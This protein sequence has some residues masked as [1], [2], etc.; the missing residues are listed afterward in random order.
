MIEHLYEDLSVHLYE[1][2]PITKKAP[3]PPPIIFL[4]QWRMMGNSTVHTDEYLTQWKVEGNSVVSN[5]SANLP[6]GYKKCKYLEFHGTEYIFSGVNTNDTIGANIS[7]STNT[8]NKELLGRRQSTTKDGFIVGMYSSN[9]IY[10]AYGGATIN[11]DINM[12]V[13][14]GNKHTIILDSEKFSVDGTLTTI[15]RGT[16]NNYY[17]IQ[18]GGWDTSAVSLARLFVGKI[19]NVKLY[20]SN[21]NLFNGIP[22]LDDNNVPCLY[23]TVTN[24]AFYNDGTG[25]FGYE[26]EHPLIYS[27][28][29]Y[30]DV[31]GKY[32]VKISNGVTIY[33]IP[34]TE[35][36]RKVNDVADTIEFAN[37]V[38]T[39]TRNLKSIDIGNMT[40]S[41]LQIGSSSDYRM[42]SSVIDA[43]SVEATNKTP[44]ML[45][46]AY[47]T[48]TVDKIYSKQTGISINTAHIMQ[49]YDPDYNQSNSASAFKTAMNGVELI[50]ELA[51]PTT[52]VIQ[53]SPFPISP[54]DTYT[55]ANDTPYSAFEYKKN[56]EIWSCGEYNPIDGKYH[57]LVQP[58]GGSIADIALDEP[59]RK[60]NDVADSIE[61][62]DGVATVTRYFQ[63]M[64]ITAS[65]I[66]IIN[67]TINCYGI[68]NFTGVKND[69]LCMC[70]GYT[71]SNVAVSE[72]PDMSV[73]ITYMF[74]STAAFRVVWRNNSCEN[75]NQF[76]ELI[77]GC[78]FIYE[79][80]TPTTEVIQA[81]QIQEAD[82][83][84][85]VISQGGKAV[86][87]S[88]FEI[89]ND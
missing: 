31:D 68:A 86:E 73:R 33:D 24:T 65:Q 5:P 35:P 60:V 88:S 50:Y 82:S 7:F 51:T 55:S 83:Y 48:T 14:D 13:Y 54:T 6:Q 3:T 10:V 69:S 79:L 84:S 64:L 30:S 66:I 8:A 76:K 22:C 87:W 42:M 39:L 70:V 2:E 80:A 81:P 4:T 28:G 62:A 41:A 44:N 75:V 63:E 61:F 29:D 58:L 9:N 32:H 15:S 74:Q 67:P 20:D 34:L 36:L 77:D 19:Y 47:T 26:L 89:N 46:I 37:G 57:I 23:D 78:Q 71:M 25:T 53:V 11:T 17:Q 59:L 72:M 40:W 85:C 12:S 52:E 45:T 56:V 38:A 18:I 49:V 27:C 43:K 1:G 16:F 21:G